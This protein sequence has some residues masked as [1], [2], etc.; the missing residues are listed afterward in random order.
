MFNVIQST[1]QSITIGLLTHATP[2]RLSSASY[3]Y[4]YQHLTY[5]HIYDVDPR[6]RA[7][8]WEWGFEKV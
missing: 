8:E 1:M 3:L 2:F 7:E 5:T 4:T 6:D